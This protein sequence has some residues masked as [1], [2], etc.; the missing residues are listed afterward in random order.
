MN[1]VVVAAGVRPED[2]R[3]CAVTTRRGAEGG[4]GEADCSGAG[5]SSVEEGEPLKEDP[6]APLERSKRALGGGEPGP[7]DVD[8]EAVLER[9]RSAPSVE[10]SDADPTAPF[11]RGG[12][13]SEEGAPA[14]AHETGEHTGASGAPAAGETC[15]ERTCKG[16]DTKRSAGGAADGAAAGAA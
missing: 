7:S 11:K 5:T 15:R 14:G 12:R 2:T 16:A 6:A 1:V 4:D 3:A 9:G 13:A 8:P 10:P